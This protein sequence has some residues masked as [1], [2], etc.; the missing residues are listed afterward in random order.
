[1]QINDLPEIMDLDQAL[2]RKCRTGRQA[3]SLCIQMADMSQEEIAHALHI[4]PGYLS[5]VIKG[6]AS[7]DSDRRI[8]LMRVCGNRAPLQYEAMVLGVS[9]SQRSPQEVLKEAMALLAAREGVT[10]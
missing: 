4:S 6:S 8:K 10:A 9:L 5:K 7:L 2:I 3:L 1:M